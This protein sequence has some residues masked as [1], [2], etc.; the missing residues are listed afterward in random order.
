MAYLHSQHLHTDENGL[1][2][3]GHWYADSHNASSSVCRNVQ[4]YSKWILLV[5]DACSYHVRITINVFDK[6][7]GGYIKACYS[8]H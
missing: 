3:H 2:G 6:I 8:E 1:S 7:L 5:L 4:Q